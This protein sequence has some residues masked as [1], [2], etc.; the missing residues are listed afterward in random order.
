MNGHKIVDRH[1]IMST[2][3]TNNHT[4]LAF[5]MKNFSL[6]KYSNVKLSYCVIAMLA[7]HAVCHST[8]VC[9][10]NDSIEMQSKY[11]VSIIDF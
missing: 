3:V 4:R 6:S 7:A 8:D 11:V 2:D 1:K 9:C 5:T 10:S